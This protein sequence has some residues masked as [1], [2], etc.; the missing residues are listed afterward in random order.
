MC[1]LKSKGNAFS[2]ENFTTCHLSALMTQQTVKKLNLWKKV[3]V[4][5]SAWITA[6]KYVLKVFP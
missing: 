3:A 2:T 5:K 6:C 1:A 4:Q